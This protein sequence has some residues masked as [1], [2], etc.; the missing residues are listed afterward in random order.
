MYEISLLSVQIN[1]AEVILNCVLYL[2]NIPAFPAHVQIMNAMPNS[3]VRPLFH[4]ENVCP[5]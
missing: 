1:R 5:I 3:F 4:V 2:L